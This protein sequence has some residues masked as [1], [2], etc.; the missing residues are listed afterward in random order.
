VKHAYPTTGDTEKLIE[1]PWRVFELQAVI[2]LH[3]GPDPVQYPQAVDK[4]N[5]WLA[6]AF[7]WLTSP[8]E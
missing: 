3:F 2:H 1:R 6:N 4:T 8:I 7:K 5:P